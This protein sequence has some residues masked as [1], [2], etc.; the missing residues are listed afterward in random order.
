[1]HC[2]HCLLRY[3][4]GAA[5]LSQRRT[6]GALIEHLLSRGL[7]DVDVAYKQLRRNIT[8]HLTHSPTPAVRQ[9]PQ[10]TAWLRATGGSSPCRSP[11]SA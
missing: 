5:V 7:I 2:L 6:V 11:H 3:I 4:S 8:V 1:M 9:Q 10:C